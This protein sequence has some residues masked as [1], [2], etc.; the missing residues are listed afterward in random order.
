MK[1]WFKY[2]IDYEYGTATLLTKDRMEGL[3][4]FYHLAGQCFGIRKSIGETK[5]LNEELIEFDGKETAPKASGENIMAIGMG[6]YS[7]TMIHAMINRETKID[8]PKE[9][10]DKVSF[11][12]AHSGD[13]IVFSD[14]KFDGDYWKLLDAGD[15]N[16]CICKTEGKPELKCEVHHFR[17][18]DHDKVCKEHKK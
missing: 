4:L 3:G 1:K 5:L 12:L 13:V 15:T 6:D 18:K 9:K 17:V 7:N 11:V 14:T 8:I 16:W 2:T 10:L